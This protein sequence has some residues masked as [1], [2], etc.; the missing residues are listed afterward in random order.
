MILPESLPSIKTFCRC[1]ASM[2]SII[3]LSRCVA[4]FIEHVGQMSASAAAG[5]IRTQACHRA[6]V[7]RYLARLGMS[8]DWRVL[9]LLAEQLLQMESRRSG[10]WAFIVDQTYN[11]QS[12]VKTEN[13]FSRANYRP[14]QKRSAWTCN[15]SSRISRRC[16][17]CF[18]QLRPASSNTATPATTARSSH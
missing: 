2:T 3:L 1:V 6:N 17:G 11:G 18:K 10:T 5:S 13:T 4:G 9:E 12:G 14:R 16:S 8:R 7:V 15:R